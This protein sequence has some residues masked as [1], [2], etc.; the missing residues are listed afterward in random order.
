[1]YSSRSSSPLVRR[2]APL[3][4]PISS[5]TPI[6]PAFNSELM[7]WDI[8]TSASWWVD[9]VGGERRGSWDRG[10]LLYRNSH[11]WVDVVV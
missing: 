1:M 11:T 3:L 4:F 9:M 5:W 7:G 8:S 6:V 2:L 10:L